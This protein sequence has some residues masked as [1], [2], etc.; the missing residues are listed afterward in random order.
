[1]LSASQHSIVFATV[2]LYLW[3]MLSL[4]ELPTLACLLLFDDNFQEDKDSHA[5]QLSPASFL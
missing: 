4:C 2:P 5:G 1:M 3:L